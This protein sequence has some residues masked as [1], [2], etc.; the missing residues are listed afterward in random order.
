[1]VLR[2]EMQRWESKSIQTA[3]AQISQIIANVASLAST[4]VAQLD[5]IDEVLARM[6][7]RITKAPQVDVEEWTSAWETEDWKKTKKRHLRCHAISWVWNQHPLHFEWTINTFTTRFYLGT[8]RFER[9]IQ[10]LSWPFVSRGLVQNTAQ[11]IFPKSIFTLKRGP[12][13]EEG[14]SKLWHQTVGPRVQTAGCT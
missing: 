13:S 3:T 4:G 10:K 5:R 11:A 9:E 8:S 2:L 6:R 12:T 7:R 1:M 14:N